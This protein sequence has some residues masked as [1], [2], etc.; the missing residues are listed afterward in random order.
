MSPVKLLRET[1]SSLID[2]PP[3]CVC[4]LVHVE[5]NLGFPASEP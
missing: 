1:F 2:F 5:F 3:L 4:Y